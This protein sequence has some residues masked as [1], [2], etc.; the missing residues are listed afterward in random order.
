MTVKSLLRQG[1]ALFDQQPRQVHRV[2]SPRIFALGAQWMFSRLRDNEP[3]APAGF[4]AAT[5]FGW[6]G[7]FKYGIS[8]L[9][10]VGSWVALAN[11]SVLLT[12]LAVLFFYVVEV[13]FLFLFPLLLDRTKQPLLTSIKAT[14][15]VGL[16]RALLGV[17]A[18]GGYMLSGLLNRRNPLR[19]WHIGCLSVLLW[20]Q[21]EVRNRL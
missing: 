17:L 18:I 1:A 12:P 11:V 6:Y 9:A 2:F 21:D 8:L 3:D 13:H 10:F 16:V 4:D 19:R 14:Y 7:C 5:P 15:R 20:Y